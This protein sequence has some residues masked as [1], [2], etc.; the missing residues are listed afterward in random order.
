LT[1]ILFKKHEMMLILLSLPPSTVMTKGSTRSLLPLL[2]S[3]SSFLLLTCFRHKANAKT[4]QRA[5]NTEPAII[6]ISAPVV[7]PCF[8]SSL[9][10]GDS[11]GPVLEGGDLLSVLRGLPGGGGVNGGG[12]DAGALAKELPPILEKNYRT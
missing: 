8:F 4:T 3:S 6:P 7:R 1:I 2:T 12:G 11:S 5:A 9:V 10:V